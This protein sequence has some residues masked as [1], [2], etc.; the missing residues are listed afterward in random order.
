MYS[1][2][3]NY[4]QHAYIHQL[5]LEGQQQK[6]INKGAKVYIQGL[7][8][9]G[10]GTLVNNIGPDA[11]TVVLGGL[12][13][14]ANDA[15][16][17]TEN[18]S[19]INIDGTLLIVQALFYTNNTLVQETLNGVTRHYDKPFGERFLFYSSINPEIDFSALIN[20]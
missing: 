12:D 18:P 15:L 14:P 20:K 10:T 11:L 16:S 9:E 17:R 4:P 6:V 19:N 2:E 5:N 7:K 3:F 8:S 13:Y 1:V